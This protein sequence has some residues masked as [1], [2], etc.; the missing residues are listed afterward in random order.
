MKKLG[1]IL[2]KILGIF[3]LIYGA[4]F[5]VFYQDLDG[6][7]MYYIWEPLMIKRYDSMKRADNTQL[8]Y[9]MK[10]AVAPAEYT[11]IKDCENNRS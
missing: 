9:M 3:A 1:K 5:A 4:L 7:F 11:E 8:P 10:D 2:L 6:K